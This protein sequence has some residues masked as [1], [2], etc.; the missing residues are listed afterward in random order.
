MVAIVVVTA[1]AT[2]A[3]SLGG[4]GWAIGTMGVSALHGKNNRRQ[5]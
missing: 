4:R 2:A 5:V 3:T 1:A